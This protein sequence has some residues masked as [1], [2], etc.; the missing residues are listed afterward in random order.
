MGRPSPRAVRR[1]GAGRAAR[2]QAE[3]F[4]TIDVRSTVHG[5]EVAGGQPRSDYLYFVGSGEFG[6][7][8]DEE[9]VGQDAA[10]TS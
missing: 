6:A 1:A 9:L 5:E 3:D 10:A 2:P 4:V 8:L 7:K